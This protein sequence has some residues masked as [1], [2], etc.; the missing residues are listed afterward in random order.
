MNN[1]RL[2]YI[3]FAFF[4]LHA[5]LASAGL[6]IDV[7]AEGESASATISTLKTNALDKV[8]A[9]AKKFQESK[10]GQKLI[11]A[12]EKAQAELGKL[13]SDIK[14]GKEMYDEAKKTY[15]KGKEVYDIGKSTYEEG[16]EHLESTQTASTL[17][18]EKERAQINEDINARKKVL[19]EELSA[20]VQNAAENEKI[21]QALAELAST[22]EEKALADEKIK[23]TQDQ[24]STYEQNL[25]D[26]LGGND[27]YFESDEEYQNLNRK[28]EETN[29]KL[30]DAKTALIGAAG[31]I[32]AMAVGKLISYTKEQKKK[33]YDEA[34]DANFV[35]ADKALDD[36]S[37]KKINK[38][39]REVFKDD[40][41]SAFVAIANTRIK[42]N[43]VEEKNDDTKFNI[44]EAD[45]AVDTRRAITNDQAVM[46]FERMADDFVI[47]SAI[48]KLESS[49]T[50]LHQDY[51]QNNP[52]KNSAQIDLDQYKTTK[53]DLEQGGR[54]GE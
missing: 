25:A 14:A 1:K 7:A 6:K 13:K 5:G 28:L 17:T 34:Q 20:R 40:I 27:D 33:M 52:N 31:G 45:V 54:K 50:L 30:E 47:E 35:S 8:N 21:Y 12:Y 4:V 39:R 10:T 37:A 26:V 15:D 44:K 29:Q 22:D 49:E 41:A 32:A 36:K 18:L 48:L 42:T 53:G 23:E 2:F 9:A 3:I 16:M 11:V 51:R 46:I 43:E 38:N 24:K 19:K